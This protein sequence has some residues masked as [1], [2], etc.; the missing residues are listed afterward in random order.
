MSNISYESKKKICGEC[1]H[2]TYLFKTEALPSDIITFGGNTKTRGDSR[3]PLCKE[4]HCFM[5]LKWRTNLFHCP[6]GKW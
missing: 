1:E 5:N 6:I 3:V 4:C 2:L